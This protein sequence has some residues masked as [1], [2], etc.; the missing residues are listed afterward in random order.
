MTSTGALDRNRQIPQM[1]FN[2]PQ[3]IRYYGGDQLLVDEDEIDN[4][5]NAIKGNNDENQQEKA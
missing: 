4:I 1:S 5:I 3:V 2:S